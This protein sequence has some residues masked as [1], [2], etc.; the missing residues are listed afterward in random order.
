MG[1]LDRSKGEGTCLCRSFSRMDFSSG[2]GTD[3]NRL[4]IS[5]ETNTALGGTVIPLIFDTRSEEFLTV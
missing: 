4:T 1:K 2:I 5:K 3:G